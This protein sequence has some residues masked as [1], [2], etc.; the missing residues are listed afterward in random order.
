MQ[1]AYG[2]SLPRCHFSLDCKSCS[3][4][5]FVLRVIKKWRWTVGMVKGIFAL[6]LVYLYISIV[7]DMLLMF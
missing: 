7:A 2:L 6:L 4:V 1:P 3:N 5:D